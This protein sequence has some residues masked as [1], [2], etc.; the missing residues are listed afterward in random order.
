MVTDPG[1]GNLKLE[2]TF[3][4][5]WFIPLTFGFEHWDLFEIGIWTLEIKR[6]RVYQNLKSREGKINYQSG[7]NMFMFRRLI[8]LSIQAA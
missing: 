7:C 6:H 4:Q 5:D 8:S 2:I 1:T 3:I